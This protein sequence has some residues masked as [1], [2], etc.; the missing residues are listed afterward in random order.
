MSISREP[1]PRLIRRR[2]IPILKEFMIR[3]ISATPPSRS[4]A[5]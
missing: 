3:R 4:T 5:R 1:D 2:K